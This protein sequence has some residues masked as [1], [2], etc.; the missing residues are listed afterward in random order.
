MTTRRRKPVQ[1]EAGEQLKVRQLIASLGGRAFVLGTRR[2]K[3]DHQGTMQTPGLPDLVAFLPVR[4][5]SPPVWRLVVVECKAPGGRLRPEQE[6][7]RELCRWANV[8]H[9]TGGYDAFV[10]WCQ[11][12][13]HLRPEHVPHYRQEPGVGVPRST[14]ENGEWENPS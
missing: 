12:R 13:G 7:F 5:S 4:A 3:G 6:T 9:V 8:E 11:Q 1:R 2:R 14:W 10:R